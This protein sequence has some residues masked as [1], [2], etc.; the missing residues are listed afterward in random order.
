[1]NKIIAG[2]L[3]H[4]RKI[5]KQEGVDALYISGTDP[6]MSEYL[7]E[8]WQTRHYY[9]GFS[10]SFGEVVIM[11]E[12]AG[13]WTDTRYFLQAQLELEGTGIEMHKLRVPGAVPVIDW[14][15]GNLKPGDRLA[16]DPFSMPFAAFQNFKVRLSAKRIE[17]VFLPHLYNET[18]QGRPPLPQKEIFVMP[19]EIAGR[20][21]SDKIESILHSIRERDASAI[22]ISA[23]DEVAWLF[24]LRGSDVRYSPLF[25]AYGIIGINHRAI[26]VHRRALTAAALELL[27]VNGIEVL[28]Y[29]QFLNY[30][31]NMHEEKFLFE[32]NSVS[33][34]V[35]LKIQEFDFVASESSLVAAMKAEKNKTEINGF[36]EAMQKDGV[37]MITFLKWLNDSIGK[38]PIS[39]YD[40]S[41]KLYELRND[42][43]GFVSESF[44]SISAYRDHGAMVHLSVDASNAYQLAPEGLLLTDSGG[45]YLMGTT[46]ITRTVALGEVSDQ[47]KH[48]F[49]L[50]LKGMIKLTLAVF[51]FGTKGIQLD[52]LAR[53]SLWE[54]GLNYGHGTGHGVGHFLSVHEGPVSIR[55]DCNPNAI[56][57]GMV[58][59]NE[60]G[61]YREG[62]YGIRIEN[63]LVCVEK[64][65]TAFG[66]FLGFDTLTL[67]PIDLRLV[68]PEML[69]PTERQWLNEYHQRVREV[70]A[71]HLNDDYRAY[72]QQITRAI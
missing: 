34:A 1:M 54:N 25:M 10:G 29:D 49:T 26:F 67:C 28:E 37:V 65:T 30:I 46:D 11:Q 19:D 55:P 72:L 52:I 20:T 56:A 14:L 32:Q 9:T 33:T 8:H 38:Y 16:V 50:V 12:S 4:V 5:L 57:P 45:Q 6:H 51:P 22:V 3:S 36:R 39:E 47:Q 2:R 68:V 48:D 59:S 70:L 24:N 27:T 18:W 31:G 53:Q 44:E 17:L 63:L 40:I 41:Q 13:L 43:S 69:S 58:F 7:T 15:V 35:G 21:V 23:V 61:I 64:E 62:E 60:P 71:P 42:Q 66:R